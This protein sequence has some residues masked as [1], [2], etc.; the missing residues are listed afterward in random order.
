MADIKIQVLRSRA[1]VMGRFD[2]S[3][4]LDTREVHRLK[5]SGDIGEIVELTADMI[6]YPGANFQWFYKDNGSDIMIGNQESYLVINNQRFINSYRSVLRMN[7]TSN[8]MYRQY[9]LNIT[10]DDGLS[11]SLQF[12]LIS[13]TVP[14]SPE[15]VLLNKTSDTICIEWKPGSKGGTSQSFIVQ[16][17]TDDKTWVNS[18]TILDGTNNG[19]VDYCIEGLEPDT[20]YYI[21]VIA[22]NKYGESLIGTL[23]QSELFKTAPRQDPYNNITLIGGGVGAVLA[24]I[25]IVIFVVLVIRRKKIKSKVIDANPAYVSVDE[26]QNDK[27]DVNNEAAENTTAAPTYASVKKTNKSKPIAEVAT[28]YSAVQKKEA[29]K[30]EDK[31]KSGVKKTMKGN[32]I[33]SERQN[34]KTKKAGEVYENVGIIGKANIGQENVYENNSL[35]TPGEKVNKDCDDLMYVD[36]KF[37]KEPSNKVIKKPVDEDKVEYGSID[38]GKRGPTPP[39]ASD[40]SDEE[41]DYLP[42]RH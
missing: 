16:H 11:N 24:L 19:R 27:E 36:L 32:D 6:S 23:S 5:V 2:C 9:Y 14:D 38:Y 7:I 25:I 21:R 41:M 4:R 37:D 13:E 26:L 39:P 12:L 3:P 8:E 29:N 20:S 35:E 28:V 31:K 30:K 33:R 10:N 18:S 17:S 34:A 42:P 40:S 1:T 15:L 22:S